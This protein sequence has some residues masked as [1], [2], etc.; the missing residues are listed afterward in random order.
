M[1]IVSK[2]NELEEEKTELVKRI[3]MEDS[4]FIVVETRGQYFGAMGNY[5]LTELYDDLEECK[6][7]VEEFSWNRAVQVM[8]LLN[9]KL[10]VNN[11]LKD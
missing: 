11:E 4:P 5:R 8:M 9:E 7:E 6:K 10:N 2:N 1:D 3:D